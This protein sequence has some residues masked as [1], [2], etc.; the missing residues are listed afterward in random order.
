MILGSVYVFF[1]LQACALAWYAHSATSGWI[2]AVFI[3]TGLMYFVKAPQWL[4]KRRDGTVPILSWIL[5][6]P[7]LGLS[8]LTYAGFRAI[9]RENASDPVHPRIFVGRRPRPQEIP[10]EVTLVIDLCAELSAHP[11]VREKYTYLA[12]PTLDGTDPTQDKLREAVEAFRTTPGAAYV[13]CAFGHGR[14][15]TVAGALLIAAHGAS[16]KTVES[17]MR[18][19]RPRIRMMG[20]QTDALRVFEESLSR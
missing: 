20:M 11:E 3:L 12:L 2:G 9:M 5:W 19:K 17:E 4:G 13:H 18:K 1:G 15:A 14:S 6:G 10:S 16:W 7:L 8:W